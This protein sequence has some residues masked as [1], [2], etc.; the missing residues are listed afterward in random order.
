ML[1]WPKDQ[2]PKEK[3]N[4]IIYIYQCGAIDCEE[5]YISETARTLGETY[6]EHLSEPLPIQVHSKLTGQQLSQD[7]FNIIGREGQDLTRLIKE[8]II[9]KGKKSHT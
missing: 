3:K 4:G 8:S 1:V 7:N 2:G 9:H 6:K 5:K